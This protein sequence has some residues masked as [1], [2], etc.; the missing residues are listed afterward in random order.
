[1][2]F[3]STITQEKLDSIKGKDNPIVFGDFLVGYSNTGKT[4]VAAGLN[5]NSQSKNDLYTFRTSET[6]S[7]DRIDWF[8]FI[9][10]S[11]IKY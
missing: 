7:I 1:M 6:T 8:L 2:M 9:P 4:A 10:I 3:S 5:L 11:T